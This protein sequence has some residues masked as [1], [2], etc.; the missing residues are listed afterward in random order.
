[1]AKKTT[2]EQTVPVE[3][4]EAGAV[5]QETL[6]AVTVTEA[7]QSTENVTESPETVTEAVES[8]TEV[9]ET[10]NDGPET[11]TEAVDPLPLHR[12]PVAVRL[13]IIQQ[14]AMDLAELVDTCMRDVPN[15]QAF[16]PI[17]LLGEVAYW[18][19]EQLGKV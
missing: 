8:V 3:P 1:M 7:A 15:S 6:E 11:V 17:S 19:A 16:T 13:S 5:E 12:Q 14:Q 9:V 2:P 4:V 10:A 18:A